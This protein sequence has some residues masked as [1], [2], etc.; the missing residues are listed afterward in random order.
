MQL[1]MSKLKA[2]E[3]FIRGYCNYDRRSGVKSN[4]TKPLFKVWGFESKNGFHRVHVNINKKEVIRLTSI[5][6]SWLLLPCPSRLPDT[7]LTC[8]NSRENRMQDLLEG[9]HAIA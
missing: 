7:F 9:M 1:L 8:M 2:V 3:F 6:F 5:F 4:G